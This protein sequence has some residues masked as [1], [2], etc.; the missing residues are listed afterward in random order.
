MLDNVFLAE[1]G[2][3]TDF[4]VKL[5]DGERELGIVKYG[6]MHAVMERMREAQI[7]ASTF[8]E[9]DIGRHGDFN[10]ADLLEPHGQNKNV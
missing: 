4:A 8:C 3:S 1:D 2:D 5:A 10:I 9:F 6:A 7:T